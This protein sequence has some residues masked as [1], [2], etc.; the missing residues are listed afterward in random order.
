[1]AVPY[2]TSKFDYT[3]L[4]NVLKKASTRKSWGFFVFVGF[5]SYSRVD[6]MGRLAYFYIVFKNRNR[7]VFQADYCGVLKT[8]IEYLGCFLVGNEAVD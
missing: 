3:F 4:S 5:Y 1:M 8:V 7:T 2:P 6:F